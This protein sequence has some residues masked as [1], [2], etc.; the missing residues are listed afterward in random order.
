MNRSGGP[1]RF[2]AFDRMSLH[3]ISHLDAS[4]FRRG[5]HLIR[6]RNHSMGSLVHWTFIYNGE[7]RW[8]HSVQRRGLDTQVTRRLVILHSPR[9]RRLPRRGD[10]HRLRRRR[11]PRSSREHW[12]P[13]PGSCRHRCRRSPRWRTRRC[14]PRSPRGLGM[15]TGSSRSTR[16]CMSS[17]TLALRR[18]WQGEAGDSSRRLPRQ[19]PRSWREKKGG[20]SSRRELSTRSV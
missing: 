20:A 19:A 11:P 7:R 18:R 12:H 5:Y 17:C 4:A 2:A 14:T 3:G 16:W 13:D 15:R 1:S 8:L 9:L 6:A 10:G